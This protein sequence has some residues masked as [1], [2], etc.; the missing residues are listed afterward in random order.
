MG[1]FSLSIGRSWKDRFVLLNNFVLR[2][3]KLGL[4]NLVLFAIIWCFC[5]KS[6][7]LYMDE[8]QYSTVTGK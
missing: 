2:D 7:N 5:S 4:V 3:W 8:H 1:E 6:H